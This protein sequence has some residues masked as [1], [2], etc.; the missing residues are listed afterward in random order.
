VFQKTLLTEFGQGR[1]KDAGQSV[2][3]VDQNKTWFEAEKD[4]QR[5]YSSNLVSVSSAAFNASF[6]QSVKSMAS[7]PQARVWIGL[8]RL[9][10]YFV[11][12]DTTPYYFENWRFFTPWKKAEG[13]NCVSAR[14]VRDHRGDAKFN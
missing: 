10:A 7:N 12:S 4:C 1:P 9:A 5:T 11:W 13:K 14:G 6:G 2:I 8:R 3:Y